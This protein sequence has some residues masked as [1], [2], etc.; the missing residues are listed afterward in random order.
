MLDQYVTDNFPTVKPPLEA[1][2]VMPPTLEARST[3]PGLTSG[4][5]E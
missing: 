1:G 3:S 2:P 4:G 5:G